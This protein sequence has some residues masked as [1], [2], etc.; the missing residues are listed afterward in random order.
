M[1]EYR[2]SGL[3]H[4]AFAE[5]KGVPV[6]TVSGWLRKPHGRK[7]IE[8]KESPLVPVVSR[9]QAV[10]DSV[11]RIDYPCGRRVEVPGNIPRG[12]LAEIL[13]VLDPRSC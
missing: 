11:I 5:A 6:S 2:A 12:E 13:A 1:K 8:K 4:R 3:T 7:T 10:R 9:P